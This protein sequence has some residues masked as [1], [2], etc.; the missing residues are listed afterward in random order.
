MYDL[1]ILG[2]GP[3]GLAATIYA[4]RKHLNVLL[5][6]HD[7]GGKANDHLQLPDVEHHLVIDGEEIINRYANEIERHSAAHS[8]DEVETVT[9]EADGYRV[10]TH[11]GKTHT[12][13]SLVIATGAQP[14]RLNVPGEKDFLMRGLSYSVLRYA[15]LF[16]NRKT[17]V[18]GDTPL[19]FRSALEL[20]QIAN[21]VT[22]IMPAPRTANGPLRRQLQMATNVILMDGYTVERIEGDQYARRLTVRKGVEVREVQADA[23]F[24][25]SDLL[26]N[27]GLVARWV[28]C[29]ANGRIKIDA[30]NR[31]SAPGIFAAGDVT[32]ADAEH[33]LIALGEG[34]KAALAA[35]EYV[36]EHPVEDMRR[37]PLEAGEWR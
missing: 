8:L 7:L 17:A 30:H 21:E 3:A 11:G 31:T 36:L 5:I 37:E 32:D 1:I 15:P 23:F 18:I 34:A 25:T 12:A 29:D 16:V 9:P 26:P 33:E 10:Q 6:T 22:L 35:Y 14:R 4:L 19:A 13:R 28:E 2:G 24:V 27:S 20:A